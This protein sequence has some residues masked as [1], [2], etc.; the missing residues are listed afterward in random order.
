MA[1]SSSFYSSSC[2]HAETLSHGPPDPVPPPHACSTQSSYAS[3]F[4]KGKY[5][6]PCRKHQIIK[7]YA[8]QDYFPWATRPSSA[9][10]CIRHPI[11]ENSLIKLHACQDYFPWATRPSSAA[12]CMQHPIII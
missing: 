7:P 5:E 3:T 2:M 9:A 10:A 8:G 6:A 12:A 4:I 11:R 1:S